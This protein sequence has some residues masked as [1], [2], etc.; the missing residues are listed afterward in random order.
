MALFPPVDKTQDEKSMLFNAATVELRLDEQMLVLSR[1]RLIPEQ[2]ATIKYTTAPPW[3]L[4]LGL[5]VMQPEQPSNIMTVAP[6][7]IAIRLN[8]RAATHAES[9]C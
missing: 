1:I 6:R 2:N 8:T 5:V 9:T 7:M 4:F 3:S